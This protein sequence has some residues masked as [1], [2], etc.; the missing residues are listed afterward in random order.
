[1]SIRTKILS[2]VDTI[3]RVP[4]LFVIDELLKIGLG[5]PYITENEIDITDTIVEP[6]ENVTTKFTDHFHTN[7]NEATFYSVIF[8]TLLRFG[9]CCLGRYHT[10]MTHHKIL[11]YKL[12]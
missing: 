11:L 1:M 3:L 5:L 12:I 7:T 8:L 4:P 2:V 9:F 6:Y 10:N